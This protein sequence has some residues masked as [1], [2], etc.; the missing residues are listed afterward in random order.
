MHLAQIFFA[1]LLEF[2]SPVSL[3]IAAVTTIPEN[4]HPPKAAWTHQFPFPS[5]ETV[6]VQQTSQCRDNEH[7]PC[8]AN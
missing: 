6:L 1:L 5:V 3:A 2:P 7:W 4:E 8:T